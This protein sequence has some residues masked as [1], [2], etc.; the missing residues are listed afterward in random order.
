MTHNLILVSYNGPVM[1]FIGWI[2]DFYKLK[3]RVVIGAE[4]DY[5]YNVQ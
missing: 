3:T 4:R 1:D 5:L 2:G